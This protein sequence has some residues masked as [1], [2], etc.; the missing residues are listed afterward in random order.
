MGVAEKH[1]KS[2]TQL[3]LQFCKN[4]WFC[5]ST[6]IGATTLE[7]LKQNIE[8]VLP[9]WI[10]ASLGVLEGLKEKW[11]AFPAGPLRGTF[12]MTS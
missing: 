3:A 4:R 12:R 5:T 6:I 11:M 9:L 2:P 8:C 1:G 10:I 7:Q